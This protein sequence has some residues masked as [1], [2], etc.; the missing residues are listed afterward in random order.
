MRPRLLSELFH[1][2]STELNVMVIDKNLFILLTTDE[3]EC[4]RNVKNVD[5]EFSILIPFDI[6]KISISTSSISILSIYLSTT[7]I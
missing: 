2:R 7:I 1:N 5:V 6:S 4:E 3:F